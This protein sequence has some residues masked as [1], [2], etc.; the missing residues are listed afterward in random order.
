MARLEGEQAVLKVRIAYA[1]VLDAT[2]AGPT[3]QSTPAKGPGIAVSCGSRCRVAS[4]DQPEQ[5]RIY[6]QIMC[7]V[8]QLFV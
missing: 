6:C 5:R 7:S 8:S 1:C 3:G 2:K 4:L